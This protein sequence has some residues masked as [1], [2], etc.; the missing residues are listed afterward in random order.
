M[1]LKAMTTVA[2]KHG[3]YA[4]YG[5]FKLTVPN[6]GPVDVLKIFGKKS[7]VSVHVP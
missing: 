2:T 4:C 6:P 7:V 3:C 1:F 5:P